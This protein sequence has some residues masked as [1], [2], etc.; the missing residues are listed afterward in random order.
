MEGVAFDIRE[1]Q[2]IEAQVCLRFCI[3]WIIIIIIIIIIV[4]KTL[5]ERNPEK[6]VLVYPVLA[7]RMFRKAGR[8]NIKTRR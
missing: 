6:Y 7:N 4:T 2:S 5:F 3:S 1:K 8:K